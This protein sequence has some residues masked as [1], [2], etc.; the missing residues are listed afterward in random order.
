M[1]NLTIERTVN[2]PRSAVWAVLADYPNISVWNSGV[3]RSDAVGDTTEGV[4]AVRVCELD[5]NVSMRET[6]T[7]WTDQQTMA[8]A[9]DD[10][11]KMPVKEAA[12]TF[13]LADA[14]DAT[15]LTMSYD[16]APKGGP[17]AGLLAAMM[18]KPMNKGF[19]GFIDDLEVAAQG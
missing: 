7:A 1:K 5:G 6:V 13:S 18:T 14:G 2:A 4:G 17:F 15:T 9:I 3:H 10:I 12:M 16:F 8:I 19:N 11:Q